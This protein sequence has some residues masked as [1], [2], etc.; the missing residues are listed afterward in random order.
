MA[1]LSAIEKRADKLATRATRNANGIAAMR[2]VP[3]TPHR[4]VLEARLLKDKIPAAA[5]ADVVNA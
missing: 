4:L 5:E 1:E 3:P 2:L